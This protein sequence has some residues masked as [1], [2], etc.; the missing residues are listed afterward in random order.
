MILIN[1]SVSP[2]QCVKLDN[3]KPLKAKDN[4]ES[5]GYILFAILYFLNLLKEGLCK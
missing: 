4:K 2:V 3:I 5:L 1:A